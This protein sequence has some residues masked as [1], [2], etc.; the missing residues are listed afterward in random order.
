MRT[1]EVR[2]EQKCFLKNNRDPRPIKFFMKFNYRSK[3]TGIRDYE[4]RQA[5]VIFHEKLDEKLD[6]IKLSDATVVSSLPST[7]S[8]SS[9]TSIRRKQSPEELRG[10]EEEDEDG[11]SSSASK[12]AR[13]EF[14][15]GQENPT[16]NVYSEL[17]HQIIPRTDSS[18]SSKV[19]NDEERMVKNDEELELYA[20]ESIRDDEE[21][22]IVCG[23]DLCNELTKW[24]QKK[25]RPRTDLG[26]YDIVDITPGSNSDFVRSLPIDVVREIRQSKHCQQLKMDDTDGMKKYIV[27]FIKAKDFRKLVD[28]SYMKTR[29]NNNTKFIWDYLNILVESFERNN[30]L[31][32]YN[33]SE[34]GYREIFL[35]PLMRSLFRGMHR[36]MNIFFGEKC[37]FASSEDRNLEKNDEEDRSAGRKIDI[38]WSMKPTDLEFSIC[39]VSGPPNQH[40][41]T[42][43]FNDK[44]KI[45]KMLKVILNRIV[46][47]YGSVGINLTS[48][49]LYGLHVYYNEI[50]VYE[51]S[52][53]SGGLYVFCEVLRSKL[54]TNEVEVGLLLRSVPALLKFRKLLEESLTDLKDYIQ[55]AC[56]RTPDDNG[57]AGLFITHTDLTPTANRKQS[58]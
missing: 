46:R 6:G 21:K 8:V 2:E 17:A 44:L 36:E 20:K 31:A 51:M 1:H 48:L 35:A 15:A 58:N 7:S 13:K 45:A 47:K 49:K 33:L 27:N 32:E 19:I 56:T 16:S 23:T 26:F 38:I 12:K 41:H 54:P 4:K 52:I 55:D 53:P 57:N 11:A 43:F 29:I 30:D 40:N 50:I 25:A 9:S 28:E 14:S 5:H 34:L 22:W 3:S 18:E 42:H 24:K 39:E 37:L 10:Y